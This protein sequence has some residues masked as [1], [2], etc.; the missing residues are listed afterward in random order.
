MGCSRDS[1]CLKISKIVYPSLEGDIDASTSNINNQIEAII[2]SL[3]A[4]YIPDDY[5]GNKVKENLS[6]I[7]EGLTSDRESIDSFSSSIDNFISQ[8]INEHE[9][10]YNAWKQAQQKKLETEQEQ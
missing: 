10:H 9:G 7:C 5:L 8:K 1:N 3:S 2:D 4:L 6:E